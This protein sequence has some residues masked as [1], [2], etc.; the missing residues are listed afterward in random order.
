MNDN[1]L[2]VSSSP[3]IRQKLTTGNVMFDVVLALLP[4]TVFG[5]Y[6][7][8]LHAFLVIAC[9]ILAA[10]LTEWI[11]DYI[12][13]K[14]NTLKDGSAV[15]T[16]LLLALSLP[17]SVPLY[18]PVLGGI[19]AILFVKCFFGGLGKNFMNPALAARCF[20]LISF[21]STMTSFSIDGVSSSTPLAALRAG[22]VISVPD[23]YLGF[24]NSVIGG[25]ALALLLGG[26]LLWVM[27]GITIEIPASCILAFTAFMVFFGGQG[28]DVPFLLTH[29]CAGGI[30]MGAFFMAT[31]PVTSP[32][33]SR[34][35]ILYGIIIGILAGLFRVK[36]TAAD[37]VSYAIIISNM[38]VPF[39]DKL[40]V[41]KP[42][43]YK[44]GEYKDY[45]F[46][47]AAVN[48]AGITLIAGLA[49]SSVYLLTKDAIGE[50]K[51]AANAASYQEVCPGAV[52]FETDAA[53]KE[54]IDALGG[55]VYDAQYGKTYINKAV[56]GMAEDGTV[57]G[58][59]ISVTSGDGFDGNITLS[60]GIAPDGTVNG[61]S[62]TELNETAGMG[63]KCGDDE[64]KGQ[65]AGVKTDAFT[66]NKAGGSTADN[67][68]DSV[69]G[70]SISSGAVVNA[71][72]TALAFFAETVQ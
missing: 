4:A 22:E 21:G 10:E 29:I 62:F 15:V 42:L 45:E 19:F 7:Y 51:E 49:L 53:M 37:S 16:G 52:S 39:I 47:K 2:N 30:L 23:I 55:D 43:G 36:G 61:I 57:A 40:P 33:T 35:Q 27:G 59:V 50:Q 72:N 14:P 28:F 32:M 1:L 54:A 26:L 34:G 18:I 64:F 70:A 31:D 38:L 65:F 67:E 25:S 68:I 11:F 20:L 12:V 9:S 63:M 69:S 60:M 58:Y 46:P 56:A 66:L 41:P 48:L 71:V 44:N 3:H 24:S 13:K 6:R 8:G 5:I 17:H